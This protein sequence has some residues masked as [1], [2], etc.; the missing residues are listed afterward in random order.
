MRGADIAIPLGLHRA[1]PRDA[2]RAGAARVWSMGW[3]SEGQAARVPALR[4]GRGFRLSPTDV[5]WSVSGGADVQGPID[6]LL[7]LLTG[8]TVVL[9]R[10]AGEGVA[11][12]AERPEALRA[13][14]L[15]EV[16]RLSR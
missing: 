11:I 10:L 4:H 15:R 8:R 7:L 5:A 16:R 14:G 2:A 12:L 9:P 3:P 1:Q 13:Q 6:A